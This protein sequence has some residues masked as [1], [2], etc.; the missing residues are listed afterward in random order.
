MNHFL[1]KSFCT[2]VCGLMSLIMISSA[3]AQQQGLSSPGVVL[4]QI[5]IN[6]DYIL[7]AVNNIPSF[8]QAYFTPVYTMAVSWNTKEEDS[9]GSIAINQAVFAAL[10]NEIAK[11]LKTQEATAASLTQQLLINGNT[12]GKQSMPINANSLS[13]SILNGQKIDPT[14]DKNTP[15]TTLAQNYIQHLSG[16]N[17]VIKQILPSKTPTSSQ[18]DY[19]NYY[20]T[21]ASIESFN[22]KVLSGLMSQ[23]D[24]SEKRDYLITQASSSDWFKKIATEDLGLVLR[25]ILM[26][27]SQMYV[28]ISRLGKALQD[29]LAAQAM[30]NTLL[31][32]QLNQGPGDVMYKKATGAMH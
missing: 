13:Y 17:F 7:T 6:T 29:L 28:E 1:K 2:L 18:T 8:I 5:K 22:V 4:Q 32:I 3:Q 25:H 19:Q 30:T 21:V 24:A 31:I 27:D 16:T 23:S 11:D 12:T 15:A 26:Y 9:G 10:N 14:L 20:D